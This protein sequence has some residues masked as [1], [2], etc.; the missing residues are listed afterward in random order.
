MMAH[1]ELWKSILADIE[2]QVSKAGFITWFKQTS[3]VDMKDGCVTVGVPN[4][5]AKE[6]LQ[7]KYHKAILHAFRN[8]LPSIKQVTY[9]IAKQLP[10]AS[11]EPEALPIK[12]K[13]EGVDSAAKEAQ[14]EIRELRVNPETNLNPRYTFANFIVGSF[15]EI[16]HASIQSAI[17]NLGKSCEPIFVYGGVGLGKTHLIQAFGNE[18]GARYPGIK[19]KYVTSEKFMGELLDAYHDAQRQLP[20]K[21]DALKERYRNID[22]FIVDDVQFLGKTEK[23][24][25][26]F[27]HTFNTLYEKNKQI[28]ISSDRHPKAIPTLE[29]R[30]RSRF[31]G[32]FVCDI[33]MPDFETRV[34]ILKL[35]S[36]EKRFPVPDDVIEYI[37]HSIKTNI[38]ELEGALNKL[39]INTKIS[40][41]PLTVD[42]AKKVL[43]SSGNVKKFT[44]PKKII[45]AVAEF[46]D[47]KE[48]DLMN[49][50]RKQHFVKPRQIVMYLLRTELSSSFPSI[51]EYLGGRDH[52]TVIHACEKVNEDLKHNLNLDEEIRSIKDK[53]YKL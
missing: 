3:I 25:E 13:K 15:N 52:S 5:F 9:I 2:L 27:F 10:E 38:R 28:I 20:Q 11:A 34:L 48:Q 17:Q 18:I 41:A 19:V 35:K 45:K 26:D 4:G 1:E 47:I 7:N 6:W 51:G 32:G 33:S 16:A 37:A 46:Y 8:S 53:I 36:N 29:E 22:A 50:S 43:S 42:E 39:I 44:T 31:E 23:M 40:N 14:A 30:L 49:Q 21:M 12:K 24:Q